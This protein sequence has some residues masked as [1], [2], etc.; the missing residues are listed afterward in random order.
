[1]LKALTVDLEGFP[2]IV[3]LMQ[4][5]VTLWSVNL[6]HERYILWS[7]DQVKT[8]SRIYRKF[9]NWL[10][11]CLVCIGDNNFGLVTVP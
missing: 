2:E 8:Y 7:A 1:M 3:R 5:Y 6:P 10:L 11:T 4:V 9:Q